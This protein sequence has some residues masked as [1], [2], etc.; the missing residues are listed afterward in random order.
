VPVV[1]GALI[2]TAALNVPGLPRSV[3]L[4][5]T[6]KELGTDPETGLIV[7]QFAPLLVVPVAVNVVTLELLLD[8]ETFCVAAMVLFGGNVKLNEFGS[9]VRGL[10]PPELAFRVTGMLSDPAGEVTFM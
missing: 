10:V 4:T 3:G 1:P 6:W 5:V 7:S 8:T 2:A 9:A